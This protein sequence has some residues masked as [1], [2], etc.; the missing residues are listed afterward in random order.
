MEGDSSYYF[1][2]LDSSHWYMREDP[3]SVLE[4]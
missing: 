2:I 3:P 4:M 1:F